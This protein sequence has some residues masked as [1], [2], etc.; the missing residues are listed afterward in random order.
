MPPQ[1]TLTV[2]SDIGC[3]WAT[4]ALHTLHDVARERGRDVRVIHRSFPLELFNARPT[5][6]RIL[7]AEIVAIAGLLPR[8]RWQPWAAD[9]ATYPVTMLPAMEAV[10][11]VADRDGV[12]AGDQLDTALRAAFYRDSRCI[13]VHPVILDVASECPLV[14]TAALAAA[15]A[16]GSGRRAVYDDWALAKRSAVQGS[17]HVISAGR[18]LHNPGVTYHWTAPP[19][20]GLPRL[21]AYDESWAIALL[22]D[23]EGEKV[24]RE[25]S[26]GDTVVE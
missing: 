6:A 1:I 23:G 22:D 14:D 13:S 20:R 18:A 4:L 10:H 25:V 12:S 7:D 15:L 5:P 8:L 17:P 24:P 2:W 11:A 26:T 16:E 9:P 19:G 21:D 3:P